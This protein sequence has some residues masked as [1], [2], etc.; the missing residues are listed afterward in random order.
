MQGL[1]QSHWT[2]SGLAAGYHQN[3]PVDEYGQPLPFYQHYIHCKKGNWFL[4]ELKKKKELG[5]VSCD[6]PPGLDSD[7]KP[8]SKS[9]ISASAAQK[10]CSV[11]V[12]WTQRNKSTANTQQKAILLG[13]VSEFSMGGTGQRDIYFTFTF[14]IMGGKYGRGRSESE[15]AWHVRRNSSSTKSSGRGNHSKSPSRPSPEEWDSILFTLVLPEFQW[16]TE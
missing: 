1:C 11:T 8:K 4:S 7:N 9:L 13:S 10:Y 12:W 5:A 6:K 15:L 3:T 16:R 14:N 2:C